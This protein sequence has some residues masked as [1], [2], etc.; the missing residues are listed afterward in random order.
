MMHTSTGTLSTSVAASPSSFLRKLFGSADAP[1]PL[2]L[3]L[4]LVLFIAGTVI[5]LGIAHSPDSCYP[6]C[7]QKDP[8]VSWSVPVGPYDNYSRP[9]RVGFFGDSRAFALAEG[10]RSVP[11]WVVDNWAIQGCGWRFAHPGTQEFGD[12]LPCDPAAYIPY[13]DHYDVAFVYAG[14]LLAQDKMT[15]PMTSDEVVANLVQSLSLI[16]ADRVVV[17]GT[18]NT[19]GLPA[20]AALSDPLALDAM[21]VDLARAAALIGVEF[22]PSFSEWV[23]GQDRSCHPDGVHFTLG[24][25]AEAGVWLQWTLNVT[26]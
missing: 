7:V 4:R 1:S 20:E 16:R 3:L 14:S 11:G 24:C 9:V 12:H 21:D 15:L 10:A 5:V 25:A 8:V 22:V 26:V 2:Q 6:N 13:S 23:D 19:F 17:L 18:P